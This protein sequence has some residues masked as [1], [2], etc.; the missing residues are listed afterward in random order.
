M[1]H[2]SYSSYVN[3]SCRCADCTR[4]ARDYQQKNRRDRRMAVGQ[5]T[6]PSERAS[7]GVPAGQSIF[8]T[9]VRVRCKCG[10]SDYANQWIVGKSRRIESCVHCR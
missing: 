10:M 8:Q 4:S 3:Q 5:R 1:T 2:G 9:G 6:D 7:T